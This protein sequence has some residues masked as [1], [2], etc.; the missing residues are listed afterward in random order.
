MRF[1]VGGDPESVSSSPPDPTVYDADAPTV[2]LSPSPA[3]PAGTDSDE[4][5][6]GVFTIDPS[7]SANAAGGTEPSIAVNPSNP[8]QIAITRFT[9]RWNNNGDFLYS[10]D[11]G[12]TWANEATIPPPPG[13]PGT[14][15]CPC[16]QTIDFGRDGTLYGTF[17]LSTATTGQIVT[18]STTDPTSGAAWRWN[19]NPAQPTSGTRLNT[20]QPWLLAN[21]DPATISQDDVYVG[22]DDFGGVA[23]RV[24]VSYGVSPVNITVDSKAGTPAPLATNPGLRLATD[25]RNGTVYALYESSTGSTQPK[26]V[27]YHLNRSTDGGLTWTLNGN[28]NGLIVE[29]VPS[30]QA[31]GFKFGSVNALLGGVDHVAVDPSN[32]D[33]YVVYGQDVSGGNQIKICRLRDNGAGGLSVG[34]AVNVST[35][36]NAALPSVA[37]LSDGTIGV[38]YDTFNGIVNGLPAF[39]AHFARSSDHGASF[40]EVVLQTFPSP[41]A[42]NGN[43][44]QRVLGDYQQLKAVGNT[45][46]G[47]YSGNR[48][49]F[50][51]TTSAIDPIFFSVPQAVKTFVGSLANPSVFT[52]SVSFFAGLTPKPDGGTVTFTVDGT[53]LGGPVP[54]NTGPGTATSI[55]TASLSVGPHTVV[56]SYSGTA[57]FQSSSGTLTQVVNRS[58]TTLVYT[59][60]TTADFDDPF[61][62]SARLTGF[63]GVPL[64]GKTL[65]FKLGAPFG[66]QLCSAVT[67]A[68]GTA[69]CQLAPNQAAFFFY[70]LTTSF[71]GDGNYFPT[72]AIASFTT[73]L[74]ETSLNYTGPSVLPNGQS[75]N[76]SARLE[77]DG[78]TPIQNRF[79]DIT[80]GS[81]ATAQACTGMTDLHGVAS[82]S[83]VVSQP[84]GTRVPIHADFAGDPYY[85]PSSDD[86]A[87]VVFV[88]LGRG[89]FT[90]GDGNA[91]KGASVTFWGA[92]WA[93]LNTLSGGTPPMSYKG[94]AADTSPG[95]P[96]CGGF[97]T[98]PGN[99]AVPPST[100]PS[101][102]AVAVTSRVRQSGSTITGTIKHIVVVQTNPGYGPDPS[103]AGSGKVVAQYC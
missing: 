41:S 97:T 7:R 9:F 103:Q 35:S 4:P 30:D 101:F 48:N 24:A 27:T 13:V 66:T 17:L 11:G 53:Q 93:K 99:V 75:V 44:R 23:A 5:A 71:D 61:T 18:G 39:S 76:L 40:S 100:V 12:I 38:L 67:D 54:V 10:T 46:Y 98:S 47:V 72:A 69:Q 26:T 25:H 83:I 15:G 68:S 77:E 78:I 74:E 81:G 6:A 56:A 21:R 8:N 89:M 2:T 16:D 37:V 102:M 84:L 29:T 55:S 31:P 90:V 64:A 79:V 91:A 22:Y 32:G 34:A 28:S 43:A 92:Q 80:L 14:T 52:Q 58:P 62:A 95:P 1:F 96:D 45:F 50:G 88:F 42:D 51:S 70:D 63:G 3:A 33:V 65:T 19:G 49:G 82:C 36:T 57:N 60:A 87:A 86:N 20:D 94:F 73:T 85:V 59:G